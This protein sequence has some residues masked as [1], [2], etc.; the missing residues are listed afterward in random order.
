MPA[1]PARI[2]RKHWPF[3]QSQIPHLEDLMSV[4]PVLAHLDNAT[5][6]ELSGPLKYHQLLDQGPATGNGLCGAV[7]EKMGFGANSRR[8]STGALR[9]L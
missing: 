3:L 5:G 7:A 4:E 1:F 2:A 6:P 9:V 8:R